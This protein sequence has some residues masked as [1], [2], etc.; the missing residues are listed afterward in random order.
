ML[1]STVL[2]FH[3]NFS[4][5]LR[6]LEMTVS[7]TEVFTEQLSTNA[8]LMIRDHCKVNVFKSFSAAKKRNLQIITSKREIQGRDVD[9]NRNKNINSS[10]YYF[11]ILIINHVLW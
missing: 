6:E 9:K 2:Q 8:S 11:W 7:A 10:T 1:I 3:S 5:V 4:R